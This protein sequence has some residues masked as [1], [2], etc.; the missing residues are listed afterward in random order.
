MYRLGWV[1]IL[2]V[3]SCAS[4]WA[5]EVRS[6]MD[7]VPGLY[8][9]WYVGVAHCMGVASEDAHRR[10]DRVD[11]YIAE[12][13][14]HTRHGTQAVGLWSEPHTITVRKDRLLDGYVVRHEAVHDLL[15]AG[16]HDSPAFRRCAAPAPA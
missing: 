3:S 7:P 16:H 13:I 5:A 6:A 2:W 10:F 1:L 14:V 4:P 8:R 9:S 12:R 11:W 15:E